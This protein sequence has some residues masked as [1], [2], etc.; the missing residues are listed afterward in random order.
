MS[1]FAL[2]LAV[3]FATTLTSGLASAQSNNV[4]CFVQSTPDVKSN[5][6]VKNQ[7]STAVAAGAYSWTVVTTGLPNKG[8]TVPAL[9]AGQQLTL[10]GVLGSGQV[11]TCSV[12]PN[13]SATRLNTTPRVVSVLPKAL[14]LVR[15]TCMVQSTPDVPSNVVVKNESGAAVSAGKY[16]WTVVTSGQPDKTGA[17][18]ALAID[19][20]LTLS[21]V[22]GSGQV[23]TCSV[24]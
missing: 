24:K 4:T 6:V 17:I 2:G 1:R 3:T 5:V 18:P 14:A 12:K 15:V 13:I 23:G 20:Q 22:L 11:G 21:H 8:G 10:S 16:T 19:Q 7:G 9:A